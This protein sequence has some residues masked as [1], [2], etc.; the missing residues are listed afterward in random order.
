M[1]DT[2]LRHPPVYGRQDQWDADDRRFRRWDR[3]ERAG[4][5]E[6]YLHLADLD[7][8]DVDDVLDF[9]STFGVLDVR[10]LDAPRIERQWFSV[11]A[12]RSTLFRA[13]R[14]YPGFGD[15]Q[16][17]SS[18][19][20]QLLAP[21]FAA[22]KAEREAAPV[23]I[24]SETLTEFRWA[25]RALRDLRTAWSCLRAGADP[26]KAVWENP[27]MPSRGDSVEL[28][29]SVTASFFELTMSDA[30]E[31]FSPRLWLRDGAKRR[32]FH[33]APSDPGPADCTLFETLVL[34][35]FRHVAEGA[36]YKRCANE[37]CAQLFVRQEGGAAH[38]QSRMTGVLYCS[39]RCAKAVA[40]RRLRRRQLERQP[41]S[42][43]PKIP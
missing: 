38:G 2:R 18:F 7:L 24:I 25:A 19:D 20:E 15:G 6:T 11:A 14:H 9:V 31:G 5:G 16:R 32:A 17:S 36:S 34:E 40:Q 37:S 39:R 29:V 35:L 43:K 12:P 27:R 8:D 26:R 28:A 4:R 30:L 23:W 3:E 1:F 22:C 21:T 42:P 10:A 41:R 13:L 33:G